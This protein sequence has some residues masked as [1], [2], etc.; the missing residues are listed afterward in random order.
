MTKISKSYI[1]SLDEPVSPPNPNATGPVSPQIVT[2][3]VF[4]PNTGRV[5]TVSNTSGSGGSSWQRKEEN[6]P[7]TDK[8]WCKVSLLLNFDFTERPIIVDSSRYAHRILGGGNPTNDLSRERNKFGNSSLRLFGGAESFITVFPDKSLNIASDDFTVET[9]LYFEEEQ[10]Q[11]GQTRYIYRTKNQNFIT[12]AT[13]GITPM[14][15][16]FYSHAGTGTLTA[17]TELPVNEWV[18]VAVSRTKKELRFFVNG[19]PDGM[20]TGVN[21]PNFFIGEKQEAWLGGNMNAYMDEFRVTKGIGRYVRQFQ[22]P[23][24]AFSA[25]IGDDGKVD[26]YWEDVVA[27]FSMDRLIESG[28][29]AD[30]SQSKLGGVLQNGATLS[31]V[32]RKF[33][34]SALLRQGNDYLS[35]TSGAF[36]IGDGNDF[37]IETWVKIKRS[38]VNASVNGTGNIFK[39]TGLSL[40]LLNYSFTL[41]IDDQTSTLGLCTEANNTVGQWIHVALVREQSIMRL[42]VNGRQSGS[43]VPDAG[44]PFTGNLLTIGQETSLN[45]AYDD[46]S[47]PLIDE[48]RFT[49]KVARYLYADGSFVPPSEPFPSKGEVEPDPYYGAVTLLIASNF[50]AP[51][52]TDFIDASLNESTITTFGSPV[53]TESNALF[54]AC[55]QIPTN[56]CLIV[57]SDLGSS[58]IEDFTAEAWVNMTSLTGTRTII[59]FPGINWFISN[60]LLGWRTLTSIPGNELTQ[61]E[62]THIAVSRENGALRL[63]KNGEPLLFS[64]EGQPESSYDSYSDFSNV[65]YGEMLIGAAPSESGPLPYDRFLNGF[66]DQIRVTRGVARYTQGF[67]VPFR[68]FGDSGCFT[69]YTGLMVPS[70]SVFSVP[71]QVYD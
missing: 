51:G 2:R 28:I 54:R 8:H 71:F 31:S 36:S 12:T 43:S 18:H 29:V 70:T 23:D 52:A 50:L 39:L 33:G 30:S 21:D 59:R 55:I 44:M 13:F 26:Y 32:D 47:R 22:V 16:L 11:Q 10:D 42:F 19:V 64:V 17:N 56:S 20:F 41:T 49:N 3:D 27:L 66:I 24:T 5:W 61:N 45:I 25:E 4:D 9:W 40:D 15:R 63:F 35:C 67:P 38:N 62:W 14:G 60:G 58:N 34:S 48:F 68:P 6:T 7:K 57:E 65:D 53:V 37:T 1:P 46:N 69:V